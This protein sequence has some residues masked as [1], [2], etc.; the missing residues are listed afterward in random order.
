MRNIQLIYA[1][2]PLHLKSI[3]KSVAKTLPFTRKF[4]K[5]VANC[6]VI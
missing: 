5:R 3:P 6:V 4:R 2:Y 1:G